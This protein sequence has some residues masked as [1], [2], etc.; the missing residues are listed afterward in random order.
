MPSEEGDTLP[1]PPPSRGSSCRQQAKALSLILQIRLIL[2]RLVLTQTK[3][4]VT[5]GHQ[6]KQAGTSAESV[7]K[8]PPQNKS[9]TKATSLKAFRQPW[10]TNGK[11]EVVFP[12]MSISVM[13]DVSARG[14]YFLSFKARRP[15]VKRPFCLT[16]KSMSK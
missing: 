2:A 13:H 6:Q 15:K 7:G 14:F 16:L 9:A 11:R 12:L 1:L 5:S 8:L 3:T 10:L 4:F